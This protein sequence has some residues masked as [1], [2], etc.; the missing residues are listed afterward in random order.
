MLTSRLPACFFL[1]LCLLL[2]TIPVC[3]DTNDYNKDPYALGLH[4]MEME[5]YDKAF[6][7]FDTLRKQEPNS[8]IYCYIGM[9]LQEQNKL[10]QAADAYHTALT[11]PASPH[12][13]SSAH[14][15]LG[16]VYKAQGK[17]PT[18]EKH[19][20]EALS[21]NPKI[22][23]AYI[24]LGEV[25]LLQRNFT[26]AESAYEQSIRLNPKFT[27][28]YYGLGRVAEFQNDFINAI[29]NYR[30]AIKQN[31]YDPQ[32]YYRLSVAY[33]RIH[34]PDASKEVIKQ[35]E[36]MK[37]YSD[38][39][40]LFRETIYKNPN[41][42]MLYVKLGELHEKHKNTTDAIR[43]YQIATTLHPSFLPAYHK[44]GTAFINQRDLE[45]ATEVYRKITEINPNDLQGW[46]KLGVIYINREN[47]DSAISAFKKAIASDDTAPQAYNNLARVYAGLGTNT[48][49]AIQLAEKAVELSPIPKH[50]DT[51]AYTYY[52]DQQYSLALTAINKALTIAPSVA[53]YLNLRNKIQEKLIE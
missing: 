41:M 38:N 39:V 10:T 26:N 28:S 21:L 4:Y 52:Q 5:Q 20:N 19:L 27:E 48:K 12:I 53:A 3:S 50:Y 47:F 31:P 13:H 29:Q 30:L 8:G 24:H 43:V 44:L 2:R 9:V 25:Y 36:L 15:H 37:S 7:A 18:A 33:R 14:L 51:L 17:L 22:P 1:T 49:K 11:F 42:P 45:K 46:L 40:H 32:S 16:I 35:F 34:K 23:E 6:N